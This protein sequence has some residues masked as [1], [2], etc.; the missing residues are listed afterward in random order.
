MKALRFILILSLFQQV[1][2]QD[3]SGDPE[4][5]VELFYDFACYSCH[6]YNAT[7]RV[8]LVDDASGIMSSEALFLSYLRLRAD[9]NPINP[10]NSMP[11][12][13]VSTLSDEQALDIYAYINSLVDDPPNLEDIPVFVEMLE[14]AKQG[15][16]NESNVE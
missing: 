16:R 9:Q 3:A 2:A 4:K 13:A 8:P 12:Y 10:K 5:G 7:M 1:H 14:S 15:T 11:N 6:G